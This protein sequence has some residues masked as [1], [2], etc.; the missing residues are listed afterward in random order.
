MK[1][2]SL[3]YKMSVDPFAMFSEVVNINDATDLKLDGILLL[4]G[5]QDISP[6]YYNED[7]VYTTAPS[8]PSQRD[9]IEEAAF[10]RAVELGIPII[11]ICR[12]AQLASCLSGHRLWQH[13][14]NHLCS[15]DVKTVDGK[16]L[17]ASADHH[18]AMRLNTCTHDYELLAA[19]PTMSVCLSQD[20]TDHFVVVPEVVYFK[21]TN[22]L[23]IQP[24]PEWMKSYDPF[25]VWCTE[26]IKKYLI[27]E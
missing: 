24:H 10:M 18:Q 26:L 11:G 7:P 5:G 20:Q 17:F 2:Y 6:S 3:F 16:T 1:L 13:V 23:A 4:H 25:N 8:T 14:E 12:G 27:K 22:C 21:N 9:L 15:H 19:A